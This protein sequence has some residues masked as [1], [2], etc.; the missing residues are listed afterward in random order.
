MQHR[1]LIMHL[2][3]NFYTVV[4]VGLVYITVVFFAPLYEVSKTAKQQKNKCNII[5]L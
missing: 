5:C 2:W 4:Y 3:G 1:E